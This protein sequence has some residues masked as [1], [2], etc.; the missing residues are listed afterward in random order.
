V[1]GGGGVVLEH[2]YG[3]TLLA[4]LLTGDP[5]AALGPDAR[6]LRI[7]FQ[8]SAF[9]PV[10]DL[11]V[12]GITP[13][14]KLRRVSVGVRRAPQFTAS[15]K[16]SVPL[17]ASY[18]KV[19]TESWEEVRAGLWR[20]ALAVASPSHA[21]R[22][23]R[24]LAVIANA[25]LSDAEFRADVQRPGKTSRDVRDRL[26][27]LDA[28]VRAAVADDKARVNAGS[29]SPA[30]LTW[31]LLSSLRILELRLEGGDETD[32][33]TTTGQLR[34]LTADGSAGSASDLFG[35][36]AN[37]ADDY[38]PAG[39]DV[40]ENSL[41]RDLAGTPL[42]RSP[43]YRRAWAI[44][45][46]LAG[47]LRDR[48]G[49][50]L[51]ETSVQVRLDRDAES[52]RLSARMVEACREPASLIVSGEPDVGKS[53]LTLA[54]AAQMAGGGTPVTVLSLRDVPETMLDLEALLGAPLAEILA[55]TATG[56]ARLLVVD[57]AEAALEGRGQLLA[58]IGTAAF[59]AGLGVVA[60]T[61]TDGAGAVERALADAATAAGRG[62]PIRQN[63]VPRLTAAE[64]GQ[65]TA[66]FA[67]VRRLA[68]DPR[69]AWL[70]GRPG[71]VD[72]LLRAGAAAALPAGP[73]SEA[74]VF[75]AVWHH[76]VR[77]R[78]VTDRGST[79][80]AREQALLALARRALLPAGPADPPD[81]AALPSLRSDGL[82]TSSG[83]ASAWLPGDQFSSDLVRD[84]AVARLLITS[85]WALLDQSGAPRWALRAARLACQAS[86][87]AAGRASEAARMSLDRSFGEIA[88]VHG[89]RW[90][91]VP[92]EALL[93]LGTAREVLV[94]AWPTLLHGRH[95]GLRV[96]LRLA[97]QRHARHAVG[98]IAVLEP[99]VDLAFCGS[100]DLGQH[101]RHH[102][103]TGEEIRH[104]VLA[105]LRGLVVDEA[106]PVPLRQQ[107]RDTILARDPAHHDE[108]SVEA[109]A[110]L[111]P[112]LGKNG[113]TFLRSLAEAGG[114]HLAPAVEPAGAARALAAS[115]P[116]LLLALAE[117][118]YIMNVGAP[119]S[120]QAF[121][122]GIR[123]HEGSRG[124]TGPLAAWYYGP[125]W[126]L[127]DNRPTDA[128]RLIN[129]MLD[130]AA[131]TRA[132]SWEGG[133]AQV[134]GLELDMPGI[135]VRWCAGDAQ[136]W[137]W[138]RG[139]STGPYPCVSALLAVERFAGQ[140]LDSRSVPAG[141]MVRLLLQDCQN[142]AMPGLVAGL[143]VRYPDHAG[144]M[145]DGW[146][147]RPEVW[148]LEAARAASEG[149]L[150]VQGPDPDDL[151]G[152]DRR[153]FSFREVAAD[154]TVRAVLDGDQDRLA[155]LAII[156]GDLVR[157]G[158]ELLADSHDVGQHM[159][160][161]QGWAAIF[162]PENHH[163]RQAGDG[164]AI[165]YQHPE[166]VAENLA[167]SLESLARG[168]TAFRL[169]AT[170][171][172]ALA[173]GRTTPTDD[174]ARDLAAARDLA[175]RPPQDGPLQVI[176]PVAAV[177]AAAVVAHS[178]QRID[179]AA[180][181]LSWC[182][183]ILVE[184]ATSM[185]RHPL[186]SEYSSHLM[187]ADRS[188]AGALPALLLLPPGRPG[189]TRKPL[190][191]PSGSAPRACPTRSA[192][193]WRKQHQ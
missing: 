137:R 10:D 88:V 43:S 26:P 30:E 78:E 35:R 98:E 190:T 18:L 97:L 34:L 144:N 90:A 24:E 171:T 14:G 67:S 46:G 160:T 122:G 70:L 8:A 177:A 21:V 180:E 113:E 89:Q 93:T 51:V 52:K 134:T 72:L 158:R 22:Q 38:A 66:A 159:A 175:D 123:S 128:L 111:G 62:G 164:V 73:L 59:R 176:D 86:L 36:L 28:L 87:I 131:A 127:L 92:L 44:L 25:N 23:V 96:L 56:E 149:R 148:Q 156:A 142:L 169:E 50:R 49:D 187:G 11:L 145:L 140:L 39:A 174:L 68:D 64:I 58:E 77:R 2:R 42:T 172:M 189:Q 57:G 154:M 147:A 105:W 153:R 5:V 55:A 33:V 114:G 80:D 166:D 150:H 173:E 81:P 167:P 188:A 53:A 65:V 192:S 91:E 4:A 120:T 168:G 31:R 112:D 139:G 32:R 76:L 151:A 107:V 136:T 118:F 184:V 85:E 117:R 69:G 129:R 143:L 20:L 63:E 157:R 135:G 163:A 83:P 110:M 185:P 108:W 100:D 138:Y 161:I 16:P 109:L 121:L 181:D 133:L 45:D 1:T 54:T 19:A 48:T 155:G 102:S 47:R 152:K 6:P 40:S 103:G 29:I 119:E 104:V 17:I 165:E 186:D 74:D 37:L 84:L 115:R 191:R 41:R 99:L 3:A 106:G 7:R 79:P 9:S 27:H 94:R 13:D 183:G 71:L 125:F 130:H 170:Y 75:A 179:L 95:A 178:Q 126:A 82:L 146:L 162:R 101:D 61:R 182:A 15:D 124:P 12:T 116:E 132:T 193:F 141:Q 60:V